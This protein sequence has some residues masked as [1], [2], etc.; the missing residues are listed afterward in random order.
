MSKCRAFTSA[1]LLVMISIITILIATLLLAVSG[2]RNSAA[3]TQRKTKSAAE[4]LAVAG[5]VTSADLRKICAAIWIDISSKYLQR[6]SLS[7]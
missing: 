3:L 6:T 7:L 4:E 1:E 5:S 2:V